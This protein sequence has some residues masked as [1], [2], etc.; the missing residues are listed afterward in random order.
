MK[1]K[2]LTYL[3]KVAQCGSISAAAEALYI[4]QPSL[5]KAVSA[6]E[7]EFGVQ[8][9]RRKA[10]GVELTAQGKSFVRYAK[11]VLAAAQA[12]EESFQRGTPGRSRLFVASQQ[13]DFLHRL[14][15]ETWQQD[16][17]PRLHYHLLETDRSSV[18]ESVLEGRADIGLLVRSATDAKS[19]PWRTQARRLHIR[20]LDRAGLYVCVG[21][22]NPYY[23]SSQV[24]LSQVER[25]PHVVLDMEQR[26]AQ[27]LFLDSQ[28]HHL[29]MERV[30]FFNS[31]GACRAFLLETDAVLYI[32]RWATGCFQD[33]RLRVLPVSGAGESATELICIRRRGDPLTAAEE[34]FLRRVC[35]ALAQGG[36]RRG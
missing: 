12:L 21:P 33:R 30:A 32:A 11:S 2:Q 23:N 4:S 14:V 1:L 15:L 28:D 31:V 10:R 8:L 34:Q 3:V 29:N 13:L 16:A 9:L 17:A 5:T 25:C 27:D 26:A 35:A 19:S 24:Q 7:E 18:T 22:G 36:G 6:L 20:I